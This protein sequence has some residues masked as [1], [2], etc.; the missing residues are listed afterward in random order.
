MQTPPR[1]PKSP[2]PLRGRERIARVVIRALRAAVGRGTVERLAIE[3]G[4]GEGT[5][6]GRFTFAVEVEEDEL[7]GGYVA[8][9][10]DLPGCVSQGETEEEAIE[11]LVEAIVGVLEVRMQRFLHEEKPRTVSDNGEHPRRRA[12]EILVT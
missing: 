5:I 3:D 12:L 6:R 8:E 7:D 11:N 2:S 10:I 4:D 1:W 9:C